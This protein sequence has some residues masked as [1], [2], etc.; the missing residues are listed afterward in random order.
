MSL[1]PNW[2]WSIGHQREI[3]RYPSCQRY[4]DWKQITFTLKHL[5][6][7]RPRLTNQSA[8]LQIVSHYSTVYFICQVY[9]VPLPTVTWYRIL[10]Q[11]KKTVDGDNLDVISTNSDL[12]VLFTRSP[13]LRLAHLHHSR[14]ILHNVDD[15]MAGNYRCSAKNRLGSLQSDFQLLIRGKIF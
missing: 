15:R 9:G 6:L 11:S 1:D 13:F 8:P 3:L 7:E 5:F 12:S 14:L 10:D 2:S 4:V